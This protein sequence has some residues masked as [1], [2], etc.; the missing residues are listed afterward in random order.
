[1]SKTEE[2]SKLFLLSFFS[3][4]QVHFRII[5]E[6]DFSLRLSRLFSREETKT[7]NIP[8]EDELLLE[9]ESVNIE[10]IAANAPVINLLNSI[11]LEA[12]NRQASDIHIDSF[13]DGFFVRYR[14]S[15]L[16]ENGNAI[17]K[18]EALSLSVRLKMLSRLNV[19][20]KRR[21]QDGRFSIQ[22][23]SSPPVDVRL[24][25]VPTVYGESIVMRLLHTEEK[26]LS[27]DKLGFPEKELSLIKQLIQKENGLVLVTGPTGSGKTTTLNAMLSYLRTDEKKIISIEDPV[28]YRIPSITQIQTDEETGM[29]FSEILKRVL[30]QDPDIIMIGEIRDTQTANLAVRAALTGHLVLA[31]LHTRYPDEAFIRL[32]DMGAAEYL[33]K[34][35]LKGVIGQELMRDENKKLKLLS[36]TLIYEKGVICC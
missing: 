20:E 31:T 32:I 12:I 10:R 19:L 2:Q 26:I 24:S 7:S 35:V 33:V 23:S 27:L 15:K 4:K 34:A 5:E 36:Q 28:E 25:I 17:S 14:V 9:K 22:V 3:D 29:T 30:R 21:A 18:E 8:N 13:V 16:I 11:I 6:K 1:T